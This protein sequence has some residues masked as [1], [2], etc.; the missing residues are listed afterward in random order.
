MSEIK[1]RSVDSNGIR[2]HVAE[3]GEGPLVVLVHGFPESWYSWRY[4]LPS[5]A[6]AG[7]RA[8]AIDVRGYGRSSAPKA[9]ED[10][11]MVKKVG[12]IVGL[13]GAL[14]E[15]RATLIGH[16]WGAPIVWTS[17]L[18]RPDL[19]RGVAG[20]SV[21]LRLECLFGFFE[22]VL[23]RHVGSEVLPSPPGA[24]KRRMMISSAL[25]RVKMRDVKVSW[26]RQVGG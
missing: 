3:C 21:R 15:A 12:D 7:Y 9:V 22:A 25:V 13:V 16:D 24:A 10:Y 19:F 14:G 5:L 18:L 6:D 1:H 26:G 4:Q 11:R 17:A 2:I 20:I 8:V 23:K